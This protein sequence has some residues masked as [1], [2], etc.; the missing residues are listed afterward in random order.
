MPEFGIQADVPCQPGRVVQSSY[1]TITPVSAA[2]TTYH[3]R[4][5]S[6]CVSTN[7]TGGGS[8]IS[9]KFPLG[10]H[11]V[12]AYG[13]NAC[14]TGDEAVVN[15]NVINCPNTFQ[16]VSKMIVS[17]NPV[18]NTLVVEVNKISQPD[19][20]KQYNIEKI[21]LIDK[22]GNVTLTKQYGPGNTKINLTVSHLPKDLYTVRVFD[23]EEWTTY[24]LMIK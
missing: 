7:I 2:S 6:N 17:P 8:T 18:T 23:G 5:V 4:S 19:I 20:N 1:F 3:W 22:L 16:S 15:F 12:Y 14:G 11:Q 10:S 9:K 13:Q 21:Q 24:Q